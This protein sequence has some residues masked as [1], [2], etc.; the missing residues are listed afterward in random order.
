MEALLAL[1][2]GYQSGQHSYESLSEHLNSQL[3]RNREGKLFTRRSVE[4]VLFNRFYEG[5]VVYHPKLPDMEL[6]DGVHQVPDEVRELWLQC[7]EVKQERA[8]TAAGH[9]RR[10]S[11]T[12]PFSRILSCWNC[13]SPYHGEAV[14][15]P[16]GEVL[17]LFHVR[18]GDGKACSTR[19]LSQTVAAVSEQFNSRVLTYLQLGARWKTRIVGALR[20]DQGKTEDAARVQRIQ[21]ALENLRK[22]HRWGDISDAEYHKEKESMQRELKALGRS[23]APVQLPN[24]ERAAQLLGDLPALWVHPG[25]TE[26]QREALIQETFVSILISGKELMTIEP[27]PNY[28]PLFA[29]LASAP[30]VGY[31]RLDSA[32]PDHVFTL[33]Q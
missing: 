32:R 23:Q 33:S 17:R 19:P 8:K 18:Q 4:H 1:L 13:G 26:L 30:K 25:V 29:T 28:A 9:P 20:R 5:K 7:Q 6:L 14:L 10:P 2:R 21:R 24:L 31:R 22:Q 15:K 3:Y 16:T 27:K 12:Y 11:R